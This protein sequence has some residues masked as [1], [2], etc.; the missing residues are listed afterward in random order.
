MVS[1]VLNLPEF[2]EVKI[3]AGNQNLTNQIKWLNILEILDELSRLHEGEFLITTAYGFDFHNIKNIHYLVNHL[4]SKRIAALALQ[5]GFYVDEIPDIFIEICNEKGL[6]LLCL[7]PS[8]SFSEITRTLSKKLFEEEEKQK[9]RARMADE[10]VKQILSDSPPCQE[11]VKHKYYELG[12]DWNHPFV[13][14]ILHVE[15]N[16]IN[17]GRVRGNLEF[18]LNQQ[19]I[20]YIVSVV[21]NELLIF[22]SPGHNQTSRIFSQLTSNLK[23]YMENTRFYFGIGEAV[24]KISEAK[25]SLMQAQKVVEFF[26]RGFSPDKNFMTYQDL[27]I[28]KLLLEIPEKVLRSYFDEILGG[29][30]AYDRKHS[31]ELLKTLEIY[32]ENGNITRTAQILYAHRHT[33]RYRLANI[34]EITGFD[35]ENGKDRMELYLAMLIKK[36]LQ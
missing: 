29:L 31:A 20:N 19:N 36:L 13:V 23:R 6:P 22:L 35:A 30:C 10:L 34:K 8:V 7:P 4:S 12:F 28:F 25:I 33:I 9:T 2:K 32:L 14:S 5:V 24:G 26:K 18:Y 27:G 15:N 3:L 16:K 21:Q 17:P 11:I 1:E